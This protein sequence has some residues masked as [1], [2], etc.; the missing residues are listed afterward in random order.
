MT[1]LQLDLY[2]YLL[3]GSCSMVSGTCADAALAGGG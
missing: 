3:S 2:I 1:G